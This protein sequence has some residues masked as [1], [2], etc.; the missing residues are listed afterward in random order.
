MQNPEQPN[1]TG[2]AINYLYICTRK[3]WF[4]RNHLEMEHTSEHVGLGQL[5]H[6]ESY[7]REKRREWDIDNLVKIDFIDKH[8][9]LHDIKSGP[10]METAHIMQLCYY[11]YLSTELSSDYSTG[12]NS[13]NQ[14]ISRQ[15]L[16][17]AI[18]MKTDANYL[19]P[20]STN[21]SNRLSH[22]GD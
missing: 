14:S 11:L 17:A 19:L 13:M 10:A 3:L 12:S 1:I 21:N 20:N 16:M 4:Y 5:L 2:T 15:T 8:G 22:I 9:V 18:S 7:P 6:N